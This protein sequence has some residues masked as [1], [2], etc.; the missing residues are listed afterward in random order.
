M[1]NY[2]TMLNYALASNDLTVSKLLW[3]FSVKVCGS[4]LLKNVFST[5]LRRLNTSL[6]CSCFQLQQRN[7][8]SVIYRKIQLCIIFT[9]KLCDG[10]SGWT[11]NI[12]WHL[13]IFVSSSLSTR[14]DPVRRGSS[15]LSSG[16]F[17]HRHW[18]QQLAS[19]APTLT[20]DIA[21]TTT[22]QTYS[23][24]RSNKINSKLHWDDIAVIYN[25]A[26][27]ESDHW[28]SPQ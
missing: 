28:S 21:L 8:A 17:W 16:R 24:L 22:A 12:K 18:Q 26:T 19:L 4:D 20:A 11:F 7:T 13:H 9:G 5:P 10:C 3:L 2:V 25:F 6:G 1:H 15:R 23:W 14:T 27:H